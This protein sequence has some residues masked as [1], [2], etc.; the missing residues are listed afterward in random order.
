[1]DTAQIALQPIAYPQKISVRVTGWFSVGN[2]T[3]YF[4]NEVAFY[5]TFETRE[6]VLM[7]AIPR[8]R[9]LLLWHS[10]END[11]GWWYNFFT[12]PQLQ[13]VEHGQLHFGARPRPALKLHLSPED[14][15]K[16]AAI[17]YISTHTPADMAQLIA[18]L[19][20]DDTGI[21]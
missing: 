8:S 10:P 19:K 2:K 3:R 7:V 18:D 16:A 17:F 9:W 13:R 5:Q 11:V 1:M 15:R 21:I 4:V 6:R 20:A 12:P 14:G